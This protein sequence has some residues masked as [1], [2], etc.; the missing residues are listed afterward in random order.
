MEDFLL[1]IGAAE[2]DIKMETMTI[3]M[4]EGPTIGETDR[5]MDGAWVDR[6]I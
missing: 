1:I 2:A 3:T 4:T 6:P 5:P